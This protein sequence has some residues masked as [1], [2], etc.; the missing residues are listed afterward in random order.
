MSSRKSNRNTR[1]QDYS[2]KDY[3]CKACDG[4]DCKGCDNQV[5]EQNQ[6]VDDSS[7]EGSDVQRWIETL[8]DV[9][10]NFLT[11]VADSGTEESASVED[12]TLVHPVDSADNSDIEELP[13]I[14]TMAEAQHL[15][16]E[17]VTASDDID[18]F[19]DEYDI[20]ELSGRIEDLDSAAK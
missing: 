6:S 14:N 7:S 17:E 15:E 16:S 3:G 10:E 9:E 1:S 4:Y 11:P 2:R 20:T 5:G 8:S 18:D 12:H 19:L 13:T